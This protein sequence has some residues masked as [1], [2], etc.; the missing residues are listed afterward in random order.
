[1]IL[2]DI[3]DLV[4]LKIDPRDLGLL[5]KCTTTELHTSLRDLQ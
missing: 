1:M 2:N 3:L 5:G 4:V